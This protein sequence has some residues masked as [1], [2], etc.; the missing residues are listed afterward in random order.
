LYWIALSLRQVIWTLDHT[1]TDPRVGTFIKA[2]NKFIQTPM[3]KKILVAMQ[4]S[5]RVFLDGGVIF[6]S[7]M[8]IAAAAT[9]RR[10]LANPEAPFPAYS[11]LI[12]A[13]LSLCTVLPTGLIYFVTSSRLRR[14][15]GRRVVW[16]LIAILA[17]IVL[18]LWL[19][20]MYKPGTYTSSYLADRLPSTKLSDPDDQHLF[21][22]YCISLEYIINLRAATFGLLGILANLSGYALATA[23]YNSAG[24]VRSP[25][26]IMQIWR[27]FTNLSCFCS[28][29]AFLA[30]YLFN[31]QHYRMNGGSTDKEN[32]WSFGQ[33]LALATWVPVV[34]EFAYIY[35]K[36][37]REAHTGKI[38]AP[39][40]VVSSTD[41][42]V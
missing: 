29:W 10:A 40:H 23:F 18:S 25:C 35:C 39:F 9:F 6:A 37:P 34:I 17:I 36:G 22:W 19:Y 26:K 7:A 27:G 2:T 31:Q 13:Y 30:V 32:D 11:A 12:T 24:V 33:I 4:H 38:M 21:D 20:L 41:L 3:I 5:T 28:V 15:R 8:L 1:E 16:A 42:E 14:T